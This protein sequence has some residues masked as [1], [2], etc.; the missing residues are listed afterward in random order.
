MARVERITIDGTEKTDLDVVFN[1][2]DPSDIEIINVIV[3]DYDITDLLTQGTID[4]PILGMLKDALH[5]RTYQQQEDK[6]E[7]KAF[8][9]DFTW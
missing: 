6:A 5:L 9:K 4:G 8:D 3:G 7:S 2:S 1:A